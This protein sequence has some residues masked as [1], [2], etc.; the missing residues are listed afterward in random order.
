[1]TETPNSPLTRS[2][3]GCNVRDMAFIPSPQDIAKSL[4]VYHSDLISYEG[5]DKERYEVGDFV[6]RRT[7]TTPKEVVVRVDGDRVCLLF[8][9]DYGW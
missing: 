3:N 6:L 8:A 2:R 5:P 9:K 7:Q 1:V 4:V